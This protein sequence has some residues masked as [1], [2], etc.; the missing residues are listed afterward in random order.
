MKACCFTG[1]RG[2]PGGEEYYRLRDR[3]EA[4]IRRAYADGYR[5]FLAGGAL[6]FDMLAAALVCSLRDSEF[7][8]MRLELILPCRDQADRWSPRDRERYAAMKA[9]ADSTVILAD[10]YFD[11]VM[12]MRNRALLEEAT[13]CI[14]YMRSPASGT[15]STVALARRRGISVVNL[16]DTS[17]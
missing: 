7:P 6:G 15:G 4:A 3:T 8:D 1:H 11:G 12:H 9:A 16:A 17:E 10:V 13:L 5:R 14:A 2:L